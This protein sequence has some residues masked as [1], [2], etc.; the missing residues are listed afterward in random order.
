MNDERPKK[1]QIRVSGTRIGDAAR[2]RPDGAPPILAT[3]RPLLRVNASRLGIK[4]PGDDEAA[5]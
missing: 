3:R 5:S 1:L 4:P 2:P